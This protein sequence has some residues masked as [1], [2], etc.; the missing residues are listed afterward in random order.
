MRRVLALATAVSLTGCSFVFTRAPSDSGA[1]PRAQPDCTSSMGFPMFD[2][3]FGGLMIAAALATAFDDNS[4]S[5]QM[6]N[7]TKAVAATLVIGAAF[8][9]SSYVGYTRV[10]RC[11][12]SR[13]QFA[14]SGPSPYGNPESYSS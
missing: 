14:A 11:Q 3:I 10:S 12:R 6:T 8:G 13:E 5:T 1:P 9:V 2:G 7:E 4:G